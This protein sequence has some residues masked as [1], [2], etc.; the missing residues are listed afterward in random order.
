MVLVLAPAA[1]AVTT[2]SRRARS[3]TI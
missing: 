1:C 2:M 3:S